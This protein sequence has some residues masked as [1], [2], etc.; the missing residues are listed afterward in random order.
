MVRRGLEPAELRANDYELP[1]AVIFAWLCAVRRR[2]WV[3]SRAGETAWLIVSV[4]GLYRTASIS[5]PGPGP[6]DCRFFGEGL[7]ER[8]NPLTAVRQ[9]ATL[10]GPYLEYWH[11]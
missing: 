7:V 2:S 10:T 9:P 5:Q 4:L 1:L 3:L 11:V 8:K 6:P